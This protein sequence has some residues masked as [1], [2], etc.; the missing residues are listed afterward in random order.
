MRPVGLVFA[1]LAAFS[2][3]VTLVRAEPV[4]TP[5]LAWPVCAGMVGPY[6]WRSYGWHPDDVSGSP[7]FHKGVDLAGTFTDIVHAADGGHVTRV[8]LLGPYGL[9]IETDAGNGVRMRYSH[10]SAVLV[11]EGGAITRGQAIGNVGA[12]GRAK[13]PQ[14]HFEVWIGDHVHNPLQYLDKS[15]GC[16]SPWPDVSDQDPAR[17]PHLRGMP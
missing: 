17:P 2:L 9:T 11:R 10:L 8:E 15:A 6:G 7:L 13:A 3:G 12:S 16:I 14:L 5:S 4:V 1:G